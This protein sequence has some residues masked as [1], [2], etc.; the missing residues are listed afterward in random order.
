VVD[1]SAAEGPVVRTVVVDH[2][3]IRVRDLE[4]S[5]RFYEAALAPLGFGVV[6]A[7][8]GGTAFGLQGAD[9]FW[10]LEGDE[11]S[12]RVHVAFA[13]PHRAAVDAFYRAALEAGGRDNG[14]PG[15]RPE[16]HAGYYG[17]FVLDPDGNNV[18]AVHHEQG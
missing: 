10:I 7:P 2:L 1:G 15:L 4:A 18:E 17:A 5:R 14:P 6:S 12:K 9:D 3:S 11:P 8:E 16:Y 13:A